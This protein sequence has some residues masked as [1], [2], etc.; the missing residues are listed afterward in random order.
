M[1]TL[2]DIP[3]EIA[4]SYGLETFTKETKPA[5]YISFENAK[6]V[7]ETFAL[8]VQSFNDGNYQA[9]MDAY[10]KCIKINPTDESSHY[11]MGLCM[12][13]MGD[14]A[15]ARAHYEKVISLKVNEPECWNNYGNLLENKFKELV[16]ARK[17]YEFSLMLDDTI[18]ETHNNLGAYLERAG[19][20]GKALREFERALELAP[21]NARFHFNY[22]N[23]AHYGL[24][25][26]RLALEEYTA[27]LE[28]DRNFVWAAFHRG[29]IYMQ[30][31]QFDKAIEDY[32]N[33]IKNA[34]N[35]GCLPVVH[36]NLARIYHSQKKRFKDADYHYK[37]AL[38]ADP[39]MADCQNNYGTLLV[40]WK[41]DPEAAKMC[42]EQSLKYLPDKPDTIINLAL[43]LEKLQKY[44]ESAEMFE[45]ALK[46]DPMNASAYYHVAGVY[47][48]NKNWKQAIE[49][50]EK[51]LTFNKEKTSVWFNLSIIYENHLRDYKKAYSC[52]KKVLEIDPDDQEARV[53]FDKIE[54]YFTQLG[55]N[56][57]MKK[58]YAERKEARE[59][60]R[61]QSRQ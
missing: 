11:N 9:A 6:K 56:E 18:P 53:E 60:A 40:E 49:K 14:Y 31:G 39:T 37:M 25:D 24:N 44:D 41:D 23:C 59:N 45:R 3:K 61:R 48:K 38:R 51:C 42:Y 46:M 43:V 13:L 17:A 28:I 35:E 54:E 50:Y 7:K 52:L 5:H 22:G 10:E 4:S 27:A 34:T 12:H 47:F 8:A 2:A 30:T 26:T 33:V 1:I 29:Q 21:K 57:A 19:E 58:S 36:K 32:K 55:R 20:N 16:R 15:G